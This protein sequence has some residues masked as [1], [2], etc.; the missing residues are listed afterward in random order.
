MMDCPD[1]SLSSVHPLALCV[2]SSLSPLFLRR[3]LSDGFAARCEA[4]ALPRRNDVFSFWALPVVRAAPLLIPN[5]STLIEVRDRTRGIAH[6]ERR[7]VAARQSLASHRPAKPNSTGSFSCGSVPC[8]VMALVGD[9]ITTIPRDSHQA[10]RL[11]KDYDPSPPG[12]LPK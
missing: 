4:K 7:L 6:H 10:P 1:L 3:L 12:F 9:F 8:S 11:Q 5:K 2:A